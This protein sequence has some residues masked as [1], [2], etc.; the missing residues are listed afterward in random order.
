MGGFLI[1]VV[2]VVGLVVLIRYMRRREVDAFLRGDTTLLEQ[3][4]IPV[5]A[6]TPIPPAKPQAAAYAARER[7]L[8]AVH[9]H[10]L[11]VVTDV[12]GEEYYVAMRVPLSDFVRSGGTVPSLRISFLI[13]DRASFA[14]VCGV[15]V[16]GAGP[17]EME[18]YER[19]KAVFDEI[20]KP[21]VVFPMVQDISDAEVREG[22]APYI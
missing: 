21:L 5:P 16:R 13:C 4:Q 14:I 3:L 22:L 7:L 9:G 8:D 18:N 6:P 1:F 11:N 15:I 17:T 19:L 2:I 20:E 12:V 10:F